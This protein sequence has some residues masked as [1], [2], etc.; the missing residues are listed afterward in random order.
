MKNESLYNIKPGDYIIVL[1]S[2]DTKNSSWYKYEFNRYINNNL[3][4]RN[5]IL[6]PVYLTKN[7][8][9]LEDSNVVSFKLF[10][11]FDKSLRK[12]VNYFRY[13]HNINFDS[14]DGYL[15]EQLSKALL[16][17]MN[18]KIKDNYQHDK[19]EYDF[20]AETSHK[21]PFGEKV[22]IKWVV[23]CKYYK[24]N[25]PDVNALKQIEYLLEDKLPNYIG[26]VITNGILTSAANELLDSMKKRVNIRVVDRIQ[27][28]KLLLKYP[29]LIKEFFIERM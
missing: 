24:Q 6:V 2:E 29:E 17:R 20:Q 9:L 23:V 11:N 4:N 7:S 25:R 21:D 10:E 13:S 14:I 12:L 22:N 27:L 3:S 18:F 28:K 1:V 8:K 15:F 19:C 5:I 16:T 26:I